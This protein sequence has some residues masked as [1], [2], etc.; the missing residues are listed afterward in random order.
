MMTSEL[1]KLEGKAAFFHPFVMTQT[2]QFNFDEAL[3]VV[4]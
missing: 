3:K 2:F 4:W 1:T